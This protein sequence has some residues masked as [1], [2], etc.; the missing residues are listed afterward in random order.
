MVPG[1]SLNSLSSGMASASKFLG[2]VKPHRVVDEQLPLQLGRRRDMRQDVDQEA[3]V[4][5]VVLEVWMRPVGAPD[6]PVWEGLD[7]LAGKGDEV[8]IGGALAIERR[9]A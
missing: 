4:G 7:D 3:V 2:P 9:R 1:M 6:D 8:A 5:H